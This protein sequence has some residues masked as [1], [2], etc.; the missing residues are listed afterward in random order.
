MWFDI[1]EVSNLYCIYIFKKCLG[2]LFLLEQFIDHS[3]I[4]GETE[5]RYSILFMM[6][7]L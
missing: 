6:V 1:Y 2:S 3:E 4:V 7:N 5:N